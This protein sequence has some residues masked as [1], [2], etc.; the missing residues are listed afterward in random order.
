[1]PERTL[2]AMVT[3]VSRDSRL[4]NCRAPGSQMLGT[5]YS[6]AQEVSLGAEKA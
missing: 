2:V 5:I 1:M 3:G 6:T 4:R